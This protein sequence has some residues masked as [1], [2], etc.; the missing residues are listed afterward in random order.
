MVDDAETRRYAY[1]DYVQ[2]TGDERWELIDGRPFNMSPA[3]SRLHQAYV[4]ELARQIGNA[5]AGNKS[6]KVYVA[7]FDVRLPAG[8]ENDDEVQTVV[9]PDIAVVCDPAKL[10]DAGCKGPPDWVIEIVSPSTDA[11]DRIEKR[12]LYLRCGVKEYWIVDPKTRRVTVCIGE[13][14]SVLPCAGK[15]ASQVV[16]GVVID[17]EL[18]G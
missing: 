11:R 5:L 12:A 13:S 3:H 15:L 7:P 6:C 18:V 9:Q 4:V 14:E 8:R 10:D 2:W 16:I 17:W 1:K